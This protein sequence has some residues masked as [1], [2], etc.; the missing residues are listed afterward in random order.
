MGKCELSYRKPDGKRETISIKGDFSIGRMM[1]SDGPPVHIEKQRSCRER[2]ALP[3][4]HK[5]IEDLTRGRG[6]EIPLQVLLEE[7][8]IHGAGHGKYERYHDGREQS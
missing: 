3:T 6:P 2:G 1:L 4:V 7:Q 8:K 5:Q